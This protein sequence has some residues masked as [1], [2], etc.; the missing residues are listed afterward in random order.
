[1]FVKIVIIKGARILS[2][3]KLSSKEIYSILSSNIVIKPTQN[4]YFEKLFEGKTLDWIKIYLLLHLAS[5]DTTLHSFQYKT[6]N[7]VLFLNK[8]L[9]NFRI[10]NTALFSFCKTFEETSINIFYDS[11]EVKSFWEKLQTKFQNTILPSLTPQAA[12]LGM[13]NE[14]SNLYD[15]LNQIFLVFKYHVYRSREK[16]ILNIDFLVDNLIKN[17]EKKPNKPC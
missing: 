17:K 7:N 8:K 11:I 6:L 13:T 9:Y 10:T 3:N 2:S 12:I 15:L 1:M 4:F 16:Y 5:I 14:A